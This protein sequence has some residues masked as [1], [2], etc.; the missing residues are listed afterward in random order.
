V[1][2]IEQMLSDFNAGVSRISQLH[3]QS[4]NNM[5][6]AAN[7]QHQAALEDQVNSTRALSN[8]LK[9]RINALEAR[10]AIGQDARMQKNIVGAVF[11]R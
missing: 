8:D 3:G 10:P 1:T 11:S 9:R 5:D 6:P 7:E 2:A 4:L